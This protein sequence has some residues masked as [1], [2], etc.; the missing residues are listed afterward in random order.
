MGSGIFGLEELL[1]DLDFTSEQ[2]DEAMDDIAKE[3]A[4]EILDKAIENVDGPKNM[5]VKKVKK[6]RESVRKTGTKKSKFKSVKKFVGKLRKK[7]DIPY[8]VS[9]NTGT[10]KR[11][12][13]IKRMGKASRKVFAD[14]NIANYA[15]HVHDGTSRMK[16]RP[17][18]DD[19]VD[20]VLDSRKYLDIAGKVI[21]DIL[22]K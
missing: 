2:I 13:K 20:D 17:F 3:V 21:D 4:T 6:G 15:C 10:L 8:P 22:N 12:L 1:E 9:V 11:S 19:A 16:A 5:D 18:L 14:R 7:N